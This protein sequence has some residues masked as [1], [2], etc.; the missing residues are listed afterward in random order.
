LYN[1]GAQIVLTVQPKG[2]KHGLEA[3]ARNITKH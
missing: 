3:A 1:F 2:T